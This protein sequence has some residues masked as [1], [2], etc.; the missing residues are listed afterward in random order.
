MLRFTAAGNGDSF[1]RGSNGVVRASLLASLAFG[2]LTSAAADLNAAEPKAKLLP[3]EP[4]RTGTVLPQ[5]PNK[6]KSPGKKEAAEDKAT[7]KNG[8]DK[9][10]AD[11]NGAENGGDKK[12][13]KAEASKYLRLT[14]DGKKLVS[15]DTATVRFVPKDGKPGPTVDLIG[16][17]HIAEDDYYKQI[18]KQFEGYDAVLYELIAPKGA[19]VK[20]GGKPN[21]AVSGMQHVMKDMLGLE[22][23]LDHI[24]Y[25]AGNMV[26]ADMTPDQLAKS[27]KDR[28]ESFFKMY[29]RAMS[30]AMQNPQANAGGELNLLFA[31]FDKNRDLALKRALAEQFE[32]MEQML[33]ALEGPNGS[34]LIAERNKVALKVLKDEIAAG[35]KKI[36]IFYGAGH[37]NDMERRLLEDFEL[38]RGQETWL[39]AWNLR[40]GKK[41]A[42]KAGAKTE[43][44]AALAQ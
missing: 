11:K 33:G 22:F 32:N 27:M 14:R 7:D 4:S 41:P 8:A 40:E 12:N 17:V 5:S 13:E 3:K 21:N 19:K 16:V 44:K 31:L 24:R 6:K 30:F 9:K 34:S 2:L 28:D 38:V 29:M 1:E 25:N 35:K 23:Q 26:H 43:K 37:M 20:A 42:N 39:P 36:A 10:G 18:N 15:L